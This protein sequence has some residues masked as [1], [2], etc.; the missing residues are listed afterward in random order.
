MRNGYFK[1]SLT[2]KESFVCLY[3]PEGG[4]EPIQI[5]EMRDYL[6]SK[7]FPG[8]DV[9]MLKNAVENLSKPQNVRIASKKGIPCPE[10]F[11]VMISR[12]KMHA[13][14]RFYPPSNGG[15]ELTVEDIK[16]TLKLEGVNKGIDDKMISSYLADR[17]YCTDYVLANGLE[18]TLGQDASI[19]YFFNTNPNLKPK[20]NEDGSV[21]FFSLSAIS[22][23]K[24]GDKL[25]TLT[26]EV[27]GEPGFNVVGDTLPPHEVRKLMLK[28]GRNIEVSEDGLTITSMVDGHASLV[29][30]KVFVSDVYEVSD[31]DTAT[32]NIDYNGNVCV[33]GNVKTGFSVKANGDI[34]VRGVVENATVEA[35]G[36]VT[37]ARGMNGMSQGTIIAGGNVISKFIE[38]ANIT[39][40]GYVHS[41]AILH[42]NVQ[43]KGDVTVTGKKG[44]I[45]GG[46]IRTPETV[47]A[48]TIGSTMGVNTEIEVGSDPKLTLRA[49]SLNGEI[50]NT[51]K[52]IDQV[53]PVILTMTTKIKAGEKLRPEQV[54][55]F[56]Q[57][58]EQYKQ[59]KE[60]LAKQMEELNDLMDSMDE[61]SGRES[62]VKVEEFAYPGTKITISDTTT[63][64]S[65]PVQHSRF[66]RE[67]ADVR[68][69]GL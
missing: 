26:K 27:P 57:L 50:A 64:L 22:L 9:V 58:S 60:E 65:K 11:R 25:A 51:K 61:T 19:E 6:V 30:D 39:A 56:K 17:H 59:L 40:G 35:S 2:D 3:P 36:N 24:K 20:L 31:V 54:L 63:V 55:Y 46:V 16:S 10:S 12:D 7:G 1:L 47:S 62:C 21:D 42:S 44:F 53:E 45:T 29:E 34:E 67:G 48:K 32:G 33:L 43:A 41:E 18:P 13:V 37:I 68:I 49:N 23:V 14:C 15:A 38:N 52:K 5:D 66:V 4:G 69:R 8:I 28:Y